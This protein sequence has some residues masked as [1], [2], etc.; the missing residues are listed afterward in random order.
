MYIATLLLCALC[1]VFSVHS[2][3]ALFLFHTLSRNLFFRCNKLLGYGIKL[4]FVLEGAAPE[5]KE[6][7][8]SQR[9]QARFGEG[10]KPGGGLLARRRPGLQ[11]IQSQCRELLDMLGLPCVQS[12]G[13]AEGTCAFLDKNGL[14]DGCITQDGDA[15]LYGARTVYRKLSIEDKDP[16]VLAYTIA[17]IE[18]KLSLDREKLIALAVLAGCD[19]YAGVHSVG[20]ETVLK[21]LVKFGDIDCL[22]RL[23]D[24]TRNPKYS[25]LQEAVDKK[26]KK[27][28]HCGNCQHPGT[29]KSHG[30]HGCEMCATDTACT[31]SSVSDCTCEW[32]KVAALQSEWK[33][34]LDI[35]RKALDKHD[36]FPPENVI[37][38]FLNDRD[39]IRSLDTCWQ[40]PSVKRFEDFMSEKLRWECGESRE[41]L[42]P[43]L[44]RCHLENNRASCEEVDD[45]KPV[46]IVKERVRRNADFYEVEWEAS[47]L[48]TESSPPNTLEPQELFKS[49]YPELVKTFDEERSQKGKKKTLNTDGTNSDIRGFFSVVASGKQRQVVAERS[50]NVGE[51]KPETCAGDV[52]TKK[53][54][55]QPTSR[56]RAAVTRTRKPKPSSPKTTSGALDRYLEK[57][58]KSSDKPLDES[59]DSSFDEFNVPLSERIAAAIRREA[60]SEP[61]SPAKEVVLQKPE[62][63]IEPLHSAV[64]TDSAQEESVIVMEEVAS[65][66]KDISKIETTLKNSVGLTRPVDISASM[67]DPLKDE[68]TTLSEKNCMTQS[69]STSASSSPNSRHVSKPPET[70]VSVEDVA[71]VVNAV[72]RDAETM[73]RSPVGEITMPENSRKPSQPSD[74]CIALS[75]SLKEEFMTSVQ[76]SD[77]DDNDRGDVGCTPPKRRNIS[78]RMSVR[79]PSKGTQDYLE[80]GDITRVTMPHV[81]ELG[82]KSQSRCSSGRR[83]LCF[84]QMTST[85]LLKDCFP[86]V[87]KLPEDAFPLKKCHSILAENLK[88]EG[89]YDQS[90]SLFDSYGESFESPKKDKPSVIVISDDEN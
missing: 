78:S 34:E 87:E 29:Q 67:S 11:A 20:K 16:H 50:G 69:D 7:T 49:V 39:E 1:G 81:T 6:D 3:C 8:L 23:R 48:W 83:K 86:R 58:P 74:F 38:E 18:M 66:G 45:L 59:P 22:E 2:N 53:S 44:T 21:L 61:Q 70:A 28:S 4:V 35:R 71:E 41:K 17:D 42:F 19:Y 60:V 63:S 33:T 89:S 68:L 62:K 76:L 15:F 47:K 55:S 37:S 84:E 79:S 56:R 26:C 13:E 27:A 30:A 14:V 9:S 88:S 24:W 77:S 54:K 31:K 36:D 43:L 5:V 64:N 25:K 52:T 80:G 40:F 65:S 46:R 57:S 51:E 82:E 73:A 85:P 90:K 32:H 72:K 75:V 10:P 12:T